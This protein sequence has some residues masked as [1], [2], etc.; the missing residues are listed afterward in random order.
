MATTKAARAVLARAAGR[1]RIQARR[2]L[3]A[4]S[5]RRARKNPSK[6]GEPPHSIRDKK[7]GHRM[8]LIL[9]AQRQPMEWVI[10][11]MLLASRHQSNSNP[12]PAV[13]EH[14]GS[15]VKTTYTVK[16]Q[17][18][19]TTARQRRAFREKVRSGEIKYSYKELARE[20]RATRSV[21]RISYPK[22][23]FMQPALAR[24]APQIP[25]MFANKIKK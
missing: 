22:R 8:R 9:Y 15:K 17:K 19:R 12:T 2:S 7:T 14:G 5:G 25:A 18:S 6:P 13:H 10:G 23:P 3:K 24:L 4:V 21:R 1:L 11:P 20:G 16:K